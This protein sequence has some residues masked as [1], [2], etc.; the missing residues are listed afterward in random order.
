M[1]P[2]GKQGVF[3]ITKH[4][5]HIGSMLYAAVKIRVISNFD[6]QQH[7]HFFALDQYLPSYGMGSKLLV[8]LKKKLLNAFPNFFGFYFS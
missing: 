8:F 3:W 7:L 2:V 6:G 4:L 5:A 1:P